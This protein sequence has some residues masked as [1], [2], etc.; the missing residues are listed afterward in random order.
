M[1]TETLE[2]VDT[3]VGDPLLDNDTPKHSHYVDKEYMG[4]AYVFGEP[5]MALCG[6]M[7]VPTR[8]PRNYPICPECE[9]LFNLGPEGRKKEW[10]SLQR[11]NGE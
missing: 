8:D 7:W 4:D 9:R 1:S 10:D 5:M 3:K 2:R 6:Y 11:N